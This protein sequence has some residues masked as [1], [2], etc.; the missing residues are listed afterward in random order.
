MA[1]CP[2]RGNGVR[3]GHADSMRLAFAGLSDVGR[4]RSA[5]EDAVH[6]RLDPTDP[7]T[8]LL[9]VADGMGG[10]AAGEVAS[11]MAVETIDEVYFAA[12][13][14]SPEARLRGAILAANERIA[15]AGEEE[16]ALRGMG[17]TC[18]ALAIVGAT[19]YIAHVGDSRGYRLRGR[20]GITRLTG[21]M[22]VWAEHVRAGGSPS[23]E[24]GRNQL[25]EAVGINP[26]L[27]PDMRGDIDVMPGDRFL[28]CSDGLW[29]LVTD[30][31]L[32]A[33][34]GGAPLDDACRSL[35]DLANR[36]GGPDNVSVILA[37]V[38]D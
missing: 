35:I 3:K 1:R 21:D 25:L 33:I 14:Q 9:V 36:R 38:T 16:E 37:A 34:A 24:F 15:R 17:T 22:S 12:R 2:Y 6:G 13:A 5:N 26:D 7:Q 30:P 20:T 18:T 28:L 27:T 10:A 31:E 32:S 19:G 4:K 29:G 23:S 11:R 8:L